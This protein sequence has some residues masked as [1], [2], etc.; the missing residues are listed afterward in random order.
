[1]ETGGFGLV[2]RRW[3]EKAMGDRLELGYSLEREIRKPA[4]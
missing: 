4:T 2:G 1:M 3:R